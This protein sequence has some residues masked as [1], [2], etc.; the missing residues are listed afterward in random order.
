MI[1]SLKFSSLLLLVFFLAMAFST[2]VQSE[3]L[4]VNGKV[5]R[6]IDGDTYWVA[7]DSLSDWQKI[8]VNVSSK[9]KRL[10]DRSLKVRLL[11]VNTEESVHPQQSRNTDF[12]RET[13]ALVKQELTGQ[14]VVL[15][16]NGV[17]RYQRPLC[18]LSV[19]G[20]DYGISLIKRGFSPYITRFGNHPWQHSEYVAAELAAKRNR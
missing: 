19:N 5:T 6:V 12:G 10:R 11:A 1:K 7:L 9:N 3:V 15:S 18:S 8:T 20:S 2:V 16:C 4:G 14:R 17:G 13:S